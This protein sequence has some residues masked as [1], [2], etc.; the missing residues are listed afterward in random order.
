MDGVGAD[1]PEKSYS[2]IILPGDKIFLP[3]LYY[4][5]AIINI[6]VKSIFVIL[7]VILIVFIVLIVKQC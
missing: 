5:T 3:I 6:H 7:I 4:F 2:R 1:V